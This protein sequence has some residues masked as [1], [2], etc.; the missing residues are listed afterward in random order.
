M[1]VAFFWLV[2]H[3]FQLRYEQ[4]LSFPARQH[5]LAYFEGIENHAQKIDESF[6]RSP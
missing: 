6:L 2:T 1:I 5:R 3:S 4:K